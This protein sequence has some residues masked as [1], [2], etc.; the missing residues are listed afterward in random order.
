MPG[1]KDT[2]SRACRW[3]SDSSHHSRRR[4]VVRRARQEPVGSPARGTGQGHGTGLSPRPGNEHAAIH[5][6]ARHQH[7]SGRRHGAERFVR[8]VGQ[9]FSAR[10]EDSH[11]Q[12][13][14]KYRPCAGSRR[15]VERHQECAVPATSHV[16]AG[17]RHQ[18]AQPQNRLGEFPVLHSPAID[19]LAR[20][21][22]RPAPQ[23]RGQCVWHRG[24]ECT[25]GVGGVH[26]GAAPNCVLNTCKMA[27][28]W[29]SAGPVPPMARRKLSP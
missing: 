14:G 4:H 16:R 11:Y 25:P 7:Q 21:N 27:N 23:S 3:R 22:Q 2:A 5:R 15:R 8:S 6:S 9:V 28:P 17:H 20:A 13:Q 26:R 12:R 29:P 18:F 24:S 10:Q 19:A 1:V